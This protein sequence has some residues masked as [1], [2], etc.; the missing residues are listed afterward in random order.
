MSRNF[1]HNFIGIQRRIDYRSEQ[2][3]NEPAPAAVN[4]V[5]AQRLG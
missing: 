3:A 2:R 1:R 5:L 4:M